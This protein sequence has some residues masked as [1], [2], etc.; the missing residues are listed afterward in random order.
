M[1][2]DFRYRG[3][4][5]R[6][7]TYRFQNIPPSAFVPER[8]VIE[9]F[10]S[11]DP[12]NQEMIHQI[13]EL[14]F[15]QRILA[16]YDTQN[17]GN[18]YHREIRCFLGLF[19]QFRDPDYQPMEQFTEELVN[20]QNRPG[21]GLIRCRLSDNFTMATPNENDRRLM[22]LVAHFSPVP[23][24]RN[25]DADVNTDMDVD[26]GSDE[27]DKGKGK[28]KFFKGDKGKDDFYKGNKG[29]DDDFYRYKGDCF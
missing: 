23:V 4:E 3:D 22:E 29:K 16:F 2:L 10:P 26:S 1:I 27:T 20:V 11:E 12:T 9:I 5:A 24:N 6:N 7:Y 15:P 8:I 25:N 19:N 17:I 28:G 21:C 13:S 14:H 18:G